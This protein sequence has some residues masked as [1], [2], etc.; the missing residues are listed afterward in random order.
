MKQGPEPS[1]GG[2]VLSSPSSSGGRLVGRVIAIAN[3]K[4]GVGKTTTVINLAAS[5]AAAERRVLVVDADPQANLTSGLGRKS[6]EPRAT[7]YDVVIDQRP[8]DEILVPTDLEHLTLAPSDRNLTGAE[9][10]LVPLMAREFR[11]REALQGV[12]GRFDYVFVDC[13]PSLGLLTVNALVAADTL[14][15]PLQCEYFALEGISELMSTMQRAQR[16][17][18][19]T[20]RIEGVLLTMVDERT[21]LAQQVMGDIRNHFKEKV[22][23]TIIPRSVRLGEAPSFGKPILLYDIRSKGAEAYLQLAKELMAHETQGAGQGAE[24]APAGA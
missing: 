15:I 21:N 19:P 10:E 14:L 24:R 9:V 1:A 12:R 2:L 18:N 3:Q 17:L 7:V 8:M 5:L 16:A 23:R 11:L 4:G 20:L 6:Q 22:F 13:P